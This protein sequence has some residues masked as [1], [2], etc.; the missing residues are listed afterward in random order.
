MQGCDLDVEA[1]KFAKNKF[2]LDVEVGMYPSS[3][4]DGPKLFI[5]SHILEHVFNPLETLKEIRLLMN[6]GDYLFIAVPGIN[7]VA[8]GDY[9]NDLRRYFHIAHVTDFTS[10]TL[11]NVANYAGFKV[12]NID[13]EINGLFVAD[14][15]SNWRKNKQDSID[16]ILSIEKTYK[17]IFP[18]L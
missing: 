8:K 15:V 13:Q 11:A 12:T 18:H 14:E 10:S 17:G 2:K 7:G 4:P 1:I 6:T 16:N 9:K 5:L 3:L